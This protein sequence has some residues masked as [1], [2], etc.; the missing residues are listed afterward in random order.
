MYHSYGMEMPLIRASFVIAGLVTGSCFAADFWMQKKPSDWNEKE[1]KRLITRSPWAREVQLSGGG[2]GGG[3][4]GGGG[5]GGRKGGGGGGGG[6]MGGGMGGGGI[7]GGDMGGGGGGDMGGGGGGGMGAGMGGPSAPTVTV[8]WDSAPPVHE[9]R[10]KLEQKD[11]AAGPAA[12]FYVV[13]IVG[14]PMRPQANPDQFKQRILK[15][16]SLERK[17]KDPIPAVNVGFIQGAKGMTVV[18]L[19]PKKDAVMDAAADKEVVFHSQMGP[20]E[21]KAKFALKDMTF[22]GKLA[23]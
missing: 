8:V 10:L 3:M 14:F 1:A 20:M 21:V 19:F 18:Y 6:A 15:G 9:A 7:G 11:Y 5:R 4:G 13:S 12:E 17:G 23:L 2:G 16:T 22:D